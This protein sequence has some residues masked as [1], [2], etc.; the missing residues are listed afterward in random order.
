MEL[1]SP[2][3][4]TTASTK[5]SS[6]L[7]AALLDSG[8]LP[9]SLASEQGWAACDWYRMYKGTERYMLLGLCLY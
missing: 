3:T 9:S 1:G 8:G 2:G 7:S 6:G 4:R 5:L